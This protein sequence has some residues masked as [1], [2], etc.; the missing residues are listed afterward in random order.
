MICSWMSLLFL[1][2]SRWAFAM[3]AIASSWISDADFGASWQVLPLRT[4]LFLETLE[5]LE[6]IFLAPLS[7]GRDPKK[8]ASKLFDHTYYQISLTSLL[9]FK[10]RTSSK[11]SVLQALNLRLEKL[12]SYNSIVEWRSYLVPIRWVIKLLTN[13]WITN[14]W[15]NKWTLEDDLATAELMSIVI[16]IKRETTKPTDFI[17]K[18]WNSFV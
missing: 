18:R 15:M 9:Y 13:E 17:R 5:I 11:A 3:F 14:E 8:N 4:L 7:R 1:S 6:V 2:I 10:I 12:N 16:E